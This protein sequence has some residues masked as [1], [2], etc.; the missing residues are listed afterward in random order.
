MATTILRAL[1][2]SRKA[3]VQSPKIAG[4]FEVRSIPI[5]TVSPEHVLIKVHAV[6]VN[7]CD[8]KMPARIHSPNTVDGCD[9]SGAIVHVGDSVARTPGSLR[10]GDR[11]AGAQMGSQARRPWS[12]AFTEYIAEKPENLWR[13]PEHYSWE[14]AASIGCAVASSVGM[15][16]WWEM[17]L[18]GTPEEPTKE[19]MFVLV[20]GGSTASGTF[21]IQLLNM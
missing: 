9:F 18:P 17:K 20:Y 2:T 15:A 5:P 8:Y 1:P 11:V 21:A 6:A 7:H 14:Q 13:L 10:I 19:P 12:G 3:I 16:L 4:T